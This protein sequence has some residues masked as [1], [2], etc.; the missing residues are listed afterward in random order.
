MLALAGSILGF[1]SSFVPKIFDHFKEKRDNAH[2]LALMDKQIEAQQAIGQ[3]KLEAVIAEADSREMSARIASDAQTSGVGWIDG[4]RAT[5]AAC[6]RLRVPPAVRSDRGVHRLAVAGQ[7]R[8]AGRCPADPLGQRNASN[9]RHHH[10]LLFWRESPPSAPRREMRTAPDAAV[11]PDQVPLEG[12]SRT[13]Y[14]DAP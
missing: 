12:W 13:P 5:V 9:F 3:T 10:R 11:A 14:D 2:E 1:V 6:H 8:V 7:W 4:L